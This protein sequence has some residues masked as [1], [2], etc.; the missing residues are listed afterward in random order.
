MSILLATIVTVSILV[1]A[2][3]AFRP[4]PTR[5]LNLELR[6]ETLA[7]CDRFYSHLR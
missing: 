4:E 6:E 7:Y 2:R 3:D 5:D 1:I